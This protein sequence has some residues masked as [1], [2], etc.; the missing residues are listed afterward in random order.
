MLK[1]RNITATPDD[2]V[3]D[4]GVEGI[5]TAIERGYLQHWRRIVRAA[6]ADPFGP[7]ADNLLQAAS[8]TDSPI[9]GLM[10]RKVTEARDPRLEVFRRVRDAIAR[11]GLGQREF[12]ARLGTSASR[13]NTYANGKAQPSA[14]TLIRIEREAADR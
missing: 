14:A 2:P 6:L 1:F 8:E 3:E 9:G 7:V 11:S 10:A 13:L 4:W 12:A 5:L